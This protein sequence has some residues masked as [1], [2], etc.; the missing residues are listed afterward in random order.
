MVPVM[1][2]H[3]PEDTGSRTAG[4]RDCAGAEAFLATRTRTDE[5]MTDLKKRE[6]QLRERLSE[7]NSRLHRI[8]DHL[9]KPADPDWEEEAQEAE[10]DEV[11]EEL[12]EAGSTEVAAIQAA[13][14]RIEAGTYGVCV[15]CGED[16]SEQRLDV[17]PHT[18][19]C[20]DCAAELA[21]ERKSATT[22][23][24]QPRPIKPS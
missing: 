10:M 6:E 15:K 7:L 2:F 14:G 13:L 8:D 19:L 23:V 1:V 21:A 18:P 9:K 24:N 20:K 17:L 4:H 3:A 11:L 12:G 22:G 5:Q 16:I